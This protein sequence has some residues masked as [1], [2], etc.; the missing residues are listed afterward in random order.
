MILPVMADAATFSFS[1]STGTFAPGKVFSVA[2]YVNPSAGEK[3]T[4]AKLSAAFSAKRLEVVSFSQS[5]GWIPLAT[6]G[7]DLVDNTTGK[8][9]KTG[10][11]PARVT[12]SKQFGTLTLKAK[13]VGTATLGIEKDSMMLDIAN[14]NKFVAST[15]ANF[16][17]ATPVTTITPAPTSS[18]TQSEV[19]GTVKTQKAS[20]KTT[21]SVTKDKTA[22]TNEVA[23]TTEVQGQTA[24]A[25]SAKTGTGSKNIWYYI[26]AFLAVLIAGGLYWNKKG[27]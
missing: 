10:G 5:T 16:V 18:T 8:L 15:G 13:N 22:T 6:P 24:S 19:S 4:V 14:A 27:N 3:I 17:I 21:S 23:T 1:P 9:I 20:K 12:S 2:V 26:L 25:A 7:S 11:F